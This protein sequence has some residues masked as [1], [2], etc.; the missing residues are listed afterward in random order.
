MQLDDTQPMAMVAEDLAEA[1]G[2]F[3][4]VVM[5]DKDGDVQVSVSDRVSLFS[6]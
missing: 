5:E 1:G 3:E 6:G 4:A 2:G